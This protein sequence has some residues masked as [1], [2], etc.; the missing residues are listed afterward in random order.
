MQLSEYRNYIAEHYP[1]FID[2]FTYCNKK[3]IAYVTEAMPK[4]LY[5]LRI[6]SY[7]STNGDT[8]ISLRYK[9]FDFYPSYFYNLE[10]ITEKSAGANVCGLQKKDLTFNNPFSI[11]NIHSE[12]LL[13]FISNSNEKEI[14]SFSEFLLKC[15]GYK[16]TD[17]QPK[18]DTQFDIIANINDKDFAFELFHHQS[19][20]I[21]KI[22]NRVKEIKQNTSCITP[23]FL[24]TTF[25]GMEI[26]NYLREENVNV[27]SIQDFTRTHFELNNSQIVHWYIKSNMTNLSIKSD[28]SEIQ[29]EGKRLISILQKCPEG[30]KNWSE[31]ERIGIGIFTYLFK[32]NF[33]KYLCEEQIENDLKNHRR[34]LLVNNNY[35]D[36]TS[37]WADVKNSYNCSA[38]IIDFKN[39]TAKLN[40]TNFFNVSKYTKKNVGNFAIIFSRKGIDNTA[41][42][43]QLQL[44]ASGKL[45]IDFTDVELIEMINEK[46]IGKDPIDRL[47]TKK[48]DL[49]K[50]Y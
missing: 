23:C 10:E 27:F 30:E 1:S 15:E 4:D 25:P 42:N 31:Y 44:F 32:D 35:S 49:V 46:M 2:N 36:S 11:D 40:S 37:F 7:F 47:E 5:E 34:D 45:L 24:F 3:V 43:E 8:T 29:L 41:K 9:Y 17:L 16:I 26:Y 38:I 20:S 28:S 18:G 12:L 48:F 33:K 39:Y 21:E 22:R 50:K 14:C 19:R 13:L 6:Q